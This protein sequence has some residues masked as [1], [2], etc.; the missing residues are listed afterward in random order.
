MDSPALVSLLHTDALTQMRKV[1][2]TERLSNRETSRPQLFSFN[3]F[4]RHGFSCYIQL[5]VFTDC[6]VPFSGLLLYVLAL[7]KNHSGFWTVFIVVIKRPIL[8]E[9]LLHDF[10]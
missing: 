4:F 1:V 10:L 7:A 3:R 9:T 5:C 8:L 6:I 2:V